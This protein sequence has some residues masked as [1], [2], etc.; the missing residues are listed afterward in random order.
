MANSR[1]FLHSFKVLLQWFSTNLLS[2]FLFSSANVHHSSFVIVP[3][4]PVVTI[5]K[6][7]EI[8]LLDVALYF[9]FDREDLSPRFF[10]FVSF[11][12]SP[13]FFFQMKRRKRKIEGFFTMAS[14]S[15]KKRNENRRQVD[16]SCYANDLSRNLKNF[17]R[18][19]DRSMLPALSL[20]KQFS[21]VMMK[22]K[23]T[24]N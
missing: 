9:Y 5:E 4:T 15:I 10:L 16:L 13:R 17:N 23:N 18:S 21:P 11:V 8:E 1:S 20:K 6:S 14:S 2:L 3:F 7:V 19:I 24:F 22:M 12:C